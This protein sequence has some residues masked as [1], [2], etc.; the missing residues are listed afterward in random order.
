MSPLQKFL[1]ADKKFTYKTVD[2]RV[3][4]SEFVDAYLPTV[5]PQAAKH[6]RSVAHVEDI[7]HRM[8]LCH[9][10]IVNGVRLGR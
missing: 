5:P 2:H 3:K 8:G 1:I 4:L 6:W 9:A 10:G 7:L